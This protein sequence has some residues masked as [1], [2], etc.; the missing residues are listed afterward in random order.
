VRD[1]ACPLS[2]RGV[3]GGVRSFAA[4]DDARCRPRGFSPPPSGA[5]SRPRTAPGAPPRAAPP[6]HAPQPQSCQRCGN[7]TSPTEPPSPLPRCA[8]PRG[9]PAAAAGSARP[10][11]RSRRLRTRIS[12]P[13]ER[14]TRISPP[15]ER[16]GAFG[17]SWL[18]PS[19][20]R[21]RRQPPCAGPA[22]TPLP[23]SMGRRARCWRYLPPPHTHTHCTKWTRLVLPPV[24]SGHVSRPATLPLLQPP[25]S[26]AW[27]PPLRLC[28]PRPPPPLPTDWTRRVPNPVQIGHSASLTPY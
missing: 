7:S 23:R 8:A 16:R 1:A 17:S 2:T 15:R 12:P 9:S 18:P 24:L 14:R 21:R 19:A 6:S 11:P 25:P 26:R 13:R 20:R 22:R 4:A 5:A 3:G 27:R 10:S 28:L